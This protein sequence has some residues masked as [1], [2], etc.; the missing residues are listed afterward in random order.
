MQAVS[1]TLIII[2][3]IKLLFQQNISKHYWKNEEKN[4]E[5]LEFLNSIHYLRL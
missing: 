5:I 1:V 2:A 4:H 3:T